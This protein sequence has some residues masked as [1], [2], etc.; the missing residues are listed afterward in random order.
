M[1]QN[2][3]FFHGFLKLGGSKWAVIV[4]YEQGVPLQRSG[5][6]TCLYSEQN[7]IWPEMGPQN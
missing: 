4:L 2:L 7:K 6:L 5:H 1:A 3:R